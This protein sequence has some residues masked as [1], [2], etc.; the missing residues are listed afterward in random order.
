MDFDTHMNSENSIYIIL[1]F[2]WP[3]TF[4]DLSWKA[5]TNTSALLS[6]CPHNTR[7]CFICILLTLK[8]YNI[9]WYIIHSNLVFNLKY[10]RRIQDRW[11]G[12]LVLTTLYY[13]QNMGVLLNTFASS[14]FFLTKIILFL[15]P[16]SYFLWCVMNR[17][18]FL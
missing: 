4:F 18:Q 14:S 1:F 15:F 10:P 3:C 8:W 6:T 12:H 2:Y 13:W 17:F 11:R 9:K 5:S 16:F 7:N